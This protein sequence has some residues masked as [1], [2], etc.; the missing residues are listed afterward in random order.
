MF[1]PD[2]H[3]EM[4]PLRGHYY[5]LVLSKYYSMGHVEKRKR[6][7]KEERSSIR[8]KRRLA[9]PQTNGSESDASFTSHSDPDNSEDEVEY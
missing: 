7:Q 9:Y 8:R 3:I 6:E 2:Y 5:K 1:R 4:M